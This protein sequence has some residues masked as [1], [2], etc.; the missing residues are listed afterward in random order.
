MFL[1][2]EIF[3]NFRNLT[4]LP[5]EVDQMDCVYF[6]EDLGFPAKFRCMYFMAFLFYVSAV[7]SVFTDIES[8]NAT[9]SF[10]VFEIFDAL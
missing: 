7:I 4:K 6:G 9:K 3:E 10:G 5:C 8:S 2:L 1:L